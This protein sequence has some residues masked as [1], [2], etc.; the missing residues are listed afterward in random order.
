MLQEERY[1]YVSTPNGWHH[2]SPNGKVGK[3][4]N[5]EIR[6][7]MKTAREFEEIRKRE[8]EARGQLQLELQFPE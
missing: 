7:D 2:L 6:I 8:A 3:K 4:V 1:L 5:P